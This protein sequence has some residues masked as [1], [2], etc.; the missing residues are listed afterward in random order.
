M[1]NMAPGPLRPTIS[2]MN[3]AFIYFAVSKCVTEMKHSVMR[4]LKILTVADEVK[5]CIV[6]W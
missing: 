6:M 3:C 2:V 4:K 1:H 5:A